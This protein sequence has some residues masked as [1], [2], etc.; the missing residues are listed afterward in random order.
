MNFY[1]QRRLSN[2]R[3]N[4]YAIFDWFLSNGRQNFCVS[5][6]P[7]QFTDLKVYRKSIY[8]TVG[9]FDSVENTD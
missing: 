4:F 3:R 1:F 2:K 8:Y 7:I 5:P 9:L 6:F